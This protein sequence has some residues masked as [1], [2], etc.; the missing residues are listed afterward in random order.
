MNHP[1]NALK[2]KRSPWPYAITGYFFLMLCG[3]ATFVT[4]AVRQNMDLVRPDYYEHE[5][6]FQ[7]Q[8]DAINRARPLAGQIAVVYDP[9]RQTLL[10]RVPS[11]HVGAHFNGTAHFYRPS[12]AKL[13]WRVDLKPAR[14]G[15]QAI[16]TTQFTPGLWKVRLLWMVN[17]EG[18]A[19]EQSVIIGELTWN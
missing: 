8:I 1:P 5:I 12:D 18:F 9:G 4:W 6:L 10:L 3:I 13:D 19:F 2:P 15:T 14:D 17:G 11:T 16:N 7:N